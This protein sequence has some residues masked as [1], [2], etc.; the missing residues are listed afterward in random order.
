[1]TLSQM[2]LSTRECAVNMRAVRTRSYSA[3]EVPSVRLPPL[4]C[5]SRGEACVVTPSQQH[6][7]RAAPEDTPGIRSGRSVQARLSNHATDNAEGVGKGTDFLPRADLPGESRGPS[8]INELL[9][10]Q[11]HCTP[12]VEQGTESGAQEAEV[13]SLQGLRATEHGPEHQAAHI[14]T[15]A[16]NTKPSAPT[17]HVATALKRKTNGSQAESQCAEHDLHGTGTALHMETSTFNTHACKMMPTPQRLVYRMS[18]NQAANCLQEGLLVGRPPSTS[19]LQRPH[20]A[21]CP[22]A[23]QHPRPS[24]TP[25]GPC[26]SSARSRVQPSCAGPTC[27]AS[28]ESL[29]NSEN[30]PRPSSVYDRAAH[31]F[32]FPQ[33]IQKSPSAAETG[34]SHAASNPGMQ[35][36]PEEPCAKQVQRTHRSS[37]PHDHSNTSAVP[38][39]GKLRKP[40]TKANRDEPTAEASK[41][42][43]SS[44]GRDES[45]RWTPEEAGRSRGSENLRPTLAGARDDSAASLKACLLNQNTPATTCAFS[46]GLTAGPV[47]GCVRTQECTGNTPAKTPK[48]PPAATPQAPS[49][50]ASDHSCSSSSSRTDHDQKHLSYPRLSSSPPSLCAYT[51]ARVNKE[52]KAL[53]REGRRRALRRVTSSEIFR[54]Q[55]WLLATASSGRGPDRKMRAL[56]PCLQEILLNATQ[57]CC[58]AAELPLLW[59]VPAHDLQVEFQHLAMEVNQDESCRELECQIKAVQ[60]RVDKLHRLQSSVSMDEMRG[61]ASRGQVTTAGQSCE[62]C[63][64]DSQ[65]EAVRHHAKLIADGL[66]PDESS[67]QTPHAIAA[68]IGGAGA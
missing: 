67:M 39:L 50:A 66:V 33:G 2:V 31:C 36:L 34:A 59:M 55:R 5:C 27:K 25:S 9:H 51:P 7:K 3:P 45:L 16:R 61:H 12:E 6:D 29:P 63:N 26:P 48:I 1:V 8:N 41:H 42:W 32:P 46:D 19:P 28:R 11:A 54:L 20:G 15:F 21:S 60:K 22:R 57:A 43:C 38:K 62:L 18:K 23:L 56:V 58:E 4:Q 35:R 40:T 47:R 13:P 10:S 68:A 49:T 24:S 44:S 52:C 17:E 64:I 30:L 65:V 14:L 37:E 53:K